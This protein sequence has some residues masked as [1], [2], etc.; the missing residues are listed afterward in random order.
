MAE[1]MFL[2]RFATKL[3]V[4]ADWR[5]E[6]HGTSANADILQAIKAPPR[7][8]RNEQGY[9]YWNRGYDQK[10]VYSLFLPAG[11]IIRIERINLRRGR[12]E[13]DIVLSIQ[14]SS[15]KTLLTK[16]KG[17][18]LTKDIRFSPTVEMF[19]TLEYE[20]VEK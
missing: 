16:K 18:P 10:D 12:Y 20:V 4:A 2:P 19:N 11:S 6:L 17:G 7:W 1:R 15:E 3:R 13:N 8:Q 5:V 14:D 9:S